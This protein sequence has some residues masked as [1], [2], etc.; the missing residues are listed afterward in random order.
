MQ[1]FR[2]EVG[3]A[4]EV[5]PGNIAGA[6]INEVGLDPE[7]VGKI[8]IHDQ[9]STVELPA[10]MP[11]E[12]FHEL[13]KV[14]VCGRQLRLSKAEAQAPASTGGG[15]GGQSKSRVKPRSSAKESPYFT[16]KKRYTK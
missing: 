16:G 14:R 13:R 12:V 6:I 9:Y 11:D 1:C 8:I 2:L 3:K 10:N 4:H 7:A 15:Y 5:K